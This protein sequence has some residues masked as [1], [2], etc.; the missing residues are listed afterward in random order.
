[1]GEEESALET[2]DFVGPDTATKL[3]ATDIDAADIRNRRVTHADLLA[4]AVNPGVA[5]R[6]RRRYSLPWS[7]GADGD[8]L[9]RRAGHIR[10][11]DDDERA[12]VEVSSGDWTD[13]LDRDIPTTDDDTDPPTRIPDRTP[14]TVIDGI[15]ETRA[16]TLAEAG[17][18]SVRAL[19][20]VD[21][22]T[23]ASTLD[24][25]ETRVRRWRDAAQKRQE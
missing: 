25:A 7:H 21:P 16:A 1:M 6:L 18:T 2:V 10:G 17:I 11:L 9:D 19:A 20:I 4:A 22:E 24:I 23:V 3:V 14:V 15:G 13:T 12:W 5:A 8:D